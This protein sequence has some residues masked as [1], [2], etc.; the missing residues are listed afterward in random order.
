MLLNPDTHFPNT[1]Y[2][3]CTYMEGKKSIESRT[4][5]KCC[6]TRLKFGGREKKN[7]ILPDEIWF[8]S[9]M[10]AAR[11]KTSN[12]FSIFI[13]SW[14]LDSENIDHVDPINREH[15]TSQ[16]RPHASNHN[17]VERVFVVNIHSKHWFYLQVGFLGVKNKVDL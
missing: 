1:S 14:M 11:D 3:Y 17:N 6:E 2:K 12:G 16:P 8:V 9:S 7:E 13:G 4:T 5:Y 10:D 15:V